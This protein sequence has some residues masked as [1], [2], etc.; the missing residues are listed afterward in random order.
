MI[1]ALTFIDIFFLAFAFLMI[2][3]ALQVVLSKNPIQSA[4]YL[5]LVFFASSGLWIMLNAE[6]LGLMLILI[7]VGAVMTLFLF[8][9]MTVNF[10]L[11]PHKTHI[12]EILLCLIILAIL[13]CAIFKALHGY[14]P[15]VNTHLVFEDS[16]THQLGS[17]LYTDYV[18]AFEIAGVILLA[19]IIAAITLNGRPLDRQRKTVKVEAQIKVKARDRLK[20]IR[21]ATEPKSNSNS[22]PTEPQS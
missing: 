6:F 8:V 16:N 4:L 21:M 19:V 20:I 7:Y 9:V 13:L 15:L 10:Q 1:T 22:D 14:H 17:L 3:S 5:V 11:L 2:V 12:T 18:Y